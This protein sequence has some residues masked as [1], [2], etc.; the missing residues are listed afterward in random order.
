MK[1]IF[2]KII[3]KHYSKNK[4]DILLTCIIMYRNN[5]TNLIHFH[6]HK[7]FIVP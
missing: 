1:K 4:F 5:V 2:L 3:V 7:H 6:F